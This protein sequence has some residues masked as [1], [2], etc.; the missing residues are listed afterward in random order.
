MKD[1]AWERALIKDV[2]HIMAR[3]LKFTNGDV[4]RTGSILAN[5]AL[6]LASPVLKHYPGLLNLI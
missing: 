3:M 1:S 5:I 6:M 2:V 4:L